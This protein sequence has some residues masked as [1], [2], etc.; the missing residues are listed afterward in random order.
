M[1]K[2]AKIQEIDIDYMKNIENGKKHLM[3]NYPN[4]KRLSK[5]LV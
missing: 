1:N 5:H 3:N 2:N 4:V